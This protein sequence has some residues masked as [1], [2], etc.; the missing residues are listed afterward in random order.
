MRFHYCYLVVLLSSLEAAVAA[1]PARGR[2]ILYNYVTE[3]GPAGERILQET[4]GARYTIV[5]AG[6]AS[7]L[8]PPKVTLETYPLYGR[9]P[10]GPGKLIV[11][12]VVGPNGRVKD[13]VVLYSTQPRNNRMVREMV[14]KWLW[15]PAKLNGAP[16]P[17]IVSHNIGF[18]RA[19]RSVGFSR[20]RR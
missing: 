3:A 1:E 15:Q 7:G 11:A 12:F 6:Q 5:P 8:I 14:S 2:P 13:P 18:S 20:P 10:G 17:A 4:Y 9:V 16:V 19:T